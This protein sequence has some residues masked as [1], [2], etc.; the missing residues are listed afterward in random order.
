MKDYLEESI[1]KAI[2]NIKK[3]LTL[4]QNCGKH[5]GT[6]NWVGQGGAMDFVH[7]NYEQWCKCCC[8]RAQITTCYEAQNRIPS[9]EKQLRIDMSDVKTGN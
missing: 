8:L 9:L 4:C 2:T 1:D 7:G 6:E 3:K 5:K